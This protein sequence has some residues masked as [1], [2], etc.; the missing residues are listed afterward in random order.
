MIQDRNFPQT[1]ANDYFEVGDGHKVYVEQ[2]GDP[3]GLPIIF[4]HG[5]PGS[6]CQHGHKLLFKNKNIR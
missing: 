1:Y 6:G 5:G 4:L 3:M 2:L